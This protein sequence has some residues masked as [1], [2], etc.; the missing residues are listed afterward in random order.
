MFSN[1]DCPLYNGLMLSALCR[2]FR[3]SRR[4]YLD[5]AAATPLDPRVARAM[6][7]FERHVFGN[8][9]SIH[10]EG[11]AARRALETQRARIARAMRVKPD[12]I[13]FTSGGTESNNLALQGVIEAR[14]RLGAADRGVHVITSAIEHPSVLEVLRAFEERGGSVTYLNVDR[15][16]NVSK[17]ELCSALRPET[18]L[19]SLMYVNSEIG[20]VNPLRELFQAARSHI[21]QHPDLSLPLFHTDAS[22]APLFLDCAPE[23][24]MV[25]LLSVD[26][27]KLHGPKGVGFL[28]VKRGSDIQPVLLGGGQERGLR[29]GTQPLALIAGL[30]EAVA[31]AQ[32]EHRETGKKVTRVRDYF[33]A[34]L[35]KEVPDARINGTKKNRVANNVNISIPGID[36]EYL[37]IQ[38]DK[39]GVATGT[40]SACTTAEDG[41]SYVL[42]ALKNSETKDA[43]RLSL[44]R[45]TRVRDVQ[46]ATRHLVACVREQ[47][48]VFP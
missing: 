19:V 16:G 31:R 48:S 23:R 10:A 42:S 38:L 36:A 7:P 8:P 46:R 18:I 33:I 27:Q 6:R 37:V 34:L 47:R 13:V 26:A 22:Q 9:S 29:A 43:I 20:V 15:E 39:R 25:D 11:I 21:K 24:L 35:E 44:G 41:S 5:Y 30:A 2:L 14:R 1:N 28:F 32:Q 3:G 4:V 45:E 17:E 12:E 40:A